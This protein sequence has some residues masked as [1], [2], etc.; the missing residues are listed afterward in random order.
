MTD[1]LDLLVHRADL[2]GLVRLVDAHT[3]TRSWPELLVL[4]DR[5]R[6]AIGTGRQ[7]WPAATLAE[8]RLAL[9]APAPIAVQVLGEEG[10]RFTIGPLT[11]VI[12]HHHTWVELRDALEPGP[13]AAMVAHERVARGEDLHDDE[14]LAGWPN[15]L[16]LPYLLAT[17][18][19][20]LDGV[21]YR[22]AGLDDPGPHAPV[23][24]APV[25]VEQA[26]EVLDDPVVE[27]AVRDLF[28]P[29]TSG[30]NGRVEVVA[31][32]GGP[33]RALGALGAPAGR[34]RLAPLGAGTA[35]AWL[36]WAGATGAAHG[37]RRGAALGRF[38]TWWLLAALDGGGDEPTALDPEQL[39]SA[40]HRF[41][42]WWFDA[43]EPAGGWRVQLVVHDPADDVSWAISAHDAS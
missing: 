7:L 19:L 18:E 40:A 35:T 14:L 23:D 39:G 25:T 33:G 9:L 11:E 43:G 20:P 16:E 34:A 30:S 24:L 15:V 17:W 32:E 2:D 42:W 41:D 27:R 37:R 12:A 1:D 38:A 36:G 10:G 31:V 6:A 13:R 22:D 4:R 8:Y 28:G 5:C 29:W 3:A 21:T 26:P